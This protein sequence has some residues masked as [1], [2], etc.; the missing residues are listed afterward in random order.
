MRDLSNPWRANLSYSLD[1]RAA[2]ITFHT[3][4]SMLDDGR[5]L[6]NHVPPDFGVVGLSESDLAHGGSIT[7]AFTQQPRQGRRQL[8]IDNEFHGTLRTAWSA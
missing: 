1:V 7:A 3:T 6:L 8:S 4:I 5:L 2:R